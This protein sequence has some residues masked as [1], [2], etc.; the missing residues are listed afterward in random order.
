MTVTRK[1]LWI[2]AIVVLAIIAARMVVLA[3]RY[4]RTP[5]P[6]PNAPEAQLGSGLGCDA[7]ELPSSLS[8]PPPP[9]PTRGE[10]PEVKL[11][12]Q[13]ITVCVLQ[14]FWPTAKITFGWDDKGEGRYDLVFPDNT[15]RRASVVSSSLLSP[16][17]GTLTF[18]AFVWLPYGDEYPMPPLV[19]ARAT[20][21]GTVSEYHAFAFDTEARMRD[22]YPPEWHTSEDHLFG[23]TYQ[24]IYSGDLKPQ[25]DWQ[26]TL[27]ID[28]AAV[29]GRVPAYVEVATGPKVRETWALKTEQADSDT[30]LMNAITSKATR[31]IRVGCQSMSGSNCVVR[32]ADVLAALAH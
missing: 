13:K 11:A 7:R 28:S 9:G 21:D 10:T 16:A 25:I 8:E 4:R 12:R 30:L 14:K 18:A 22:K 17:R 24:G 6:A 23:F 5:P 31:E 1:R 19:V 26:G 3:P 15:Y 2:I 27:D 29:I 20:T 32:T